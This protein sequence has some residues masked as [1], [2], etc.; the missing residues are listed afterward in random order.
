MAMLKSRRLGMIVSLPITA[1]P[2]FVFIWAM[3]INHIVIYTC[4]NTARATLV[5]VCFYLLRM[6]WKFLLVI[7]F[8]HILWK[9]IKLCYILKFWVN[10]SLRGAP[11]TCW[12]LTEAIQPSLSVLI[13]RAHSKP[14]SCAGFYFRP[15]K[16]FNG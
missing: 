1:L 3:V 14:N 9:V 7:I 6:C 10:S 13:R 5:I 11:M 8:F 15:V 12:R 4:I 2:L 16:A